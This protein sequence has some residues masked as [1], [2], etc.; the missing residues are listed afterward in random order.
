MNVP[1]VRT[2]AATSSRG[3][4]G[5]R[6]SSAKTGRAGASPERFDSIA[7][8]RKLIAH[9]TLEE[10]GQFKRFNGETVAF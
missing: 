9:W 10:S 8:M 3:G 7:G 1:V 5:T 2:S 4:I 6:G